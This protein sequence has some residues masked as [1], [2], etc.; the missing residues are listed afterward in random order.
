MKAVGNDDKIALVKKAEDA[1]NIIPLLYPDFKESLSALDVLEV[2][3]RN[4]LYFLNER[5]RPDDLVLYFLTLLSK[6]TG[7]VIFIDTDAPV[8]P[9]TSHRTKVQ[10]LSDKTTCFL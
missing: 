6:E 9:G 7:K 1:E 3:F 5:E 8:F 4:V 10:R 2:S